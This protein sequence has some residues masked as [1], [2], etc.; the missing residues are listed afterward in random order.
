MS[1]IRKDIYR[2]DITNN[3]YFLVFHKVLNIG[4]GPSLAICFNN[5]E[6]LKFDIYGK[7]KGHYHIYNKNGQTIY[8]KEETA[9]EQINAVNN[10]LKNNIG[11]YLSKSDRIDIRTFEINMDIFVE[12]VNDAINKLIEYEEKYYAFKRDI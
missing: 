6:Y 11:I 12:K 1:N 4:E 9:M 3:L 2:I 8:F 7:D 5:Y 10:D